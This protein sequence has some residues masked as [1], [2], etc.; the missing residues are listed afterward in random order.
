[1]T[2]KHRKGF[3]LV[4][5]MA[6][7]V[8]LTIG[9]SAILVLIARATSA[10]NTARIVTVQTS[11]ARLAMVRVENEYWQGNANRI[12]TSGDFGADFPT[13][14]YTVTV[15]EDIDEEIPALHLIELTVYDTTE[16][17]QPYTITT[18]LLDFS[19]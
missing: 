13:F 17:V 9:V 6:A 18:Y 12:D 7:V 19:R 15:T 4:E 10:V 14:H 3:T 1:M 5:T 2:H 11:L 16:R 8:V